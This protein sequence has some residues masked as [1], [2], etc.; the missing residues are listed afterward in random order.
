VRNQR[1]TDLRVII[2]RRPLQQREQQ[3]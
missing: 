1:E 3:R 2:G